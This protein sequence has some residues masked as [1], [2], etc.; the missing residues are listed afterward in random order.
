MNVKVK[1]SIEQF[2]WLLHWVHNFVQQNTAALNEVQLI[3]LKCFTAKGF[4][5][6]IDLNSEMQLNPTKI[7]TFAIEFNQFHT[8][9]NCLD[10]F[11]DSLDA[12]TVSIAET[13]RAG[14]S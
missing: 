2:K 13:M 8:V 3:N 6:L 12:Y 1:L 11:Y 9:L 7:K 10:S 4:K 14:N 5:K